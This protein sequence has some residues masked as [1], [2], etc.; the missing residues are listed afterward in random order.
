MHRRRGKLA[1]LSSVTIPVFKAREG[2]LGRVTFIWD[3]SSSLW[4]C[5]ECVALLT[6]CDV[7]QSSTESFSIS[8]G[9]NTFLFLGE[10]HDGS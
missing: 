9:T 8:V 1:L 10:E 2:K 4:P 7:V 6:L 3:K 5:R